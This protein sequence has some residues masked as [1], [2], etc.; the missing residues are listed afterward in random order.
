M[1]DTHLINVA[2]VG[3][4]ISAGVAI[5]IA[6]AIIGIAAA[7]LHRKASRS[8]SLGTQRPATEGHNGI[9][10]PAREPERQA[11]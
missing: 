6:A 2:L 1:F 11:A 10:A 9:S 7:R 4:S 3:L 8:G 5:L